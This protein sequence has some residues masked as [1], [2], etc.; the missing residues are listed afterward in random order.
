MPK[1]KA[2]KK[3]PQ[4]KPDGRKSVNFY[5]CEKKIKEFDKL[6]RICGMKRTELLVHLMDGFISGADEAFIQNWKDAHL[7]MLKEVSRRI[8][9]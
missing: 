9:V 2:K 5:V 6:A 7:A 4:R 8:N 1:K 3:V